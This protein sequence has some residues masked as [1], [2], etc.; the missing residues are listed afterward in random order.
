[1]EQNLICIGLIGKYCSGKDT[2]A[3]M[4]MRYFNTQLYGEGFTGKIFSTDQKYD[5]LS[6]LIYH[7]TG[8]LKDRLNWR[9]ALSV[10]GK[11]TLVGSLFYESL[12]FSQLDH[13]GKRPVAIIN[14]VETEEQ[15]EDWLR[16]IPNKTHFIYIRSDLETRFKNHNSRKFDPDSIEEFREICKTYGDTHIGSLRRYAGPTNIAANIGFREKHISDLDGLYNLQKGIY[17]I[18]DDIVLK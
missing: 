17:A 4:I 16:F 14:S 11:S 5:E 3:N 9:K 7:N 13:G 8:T 2:A 6:Q 15:A 18:L 10:M 1:M 12:L